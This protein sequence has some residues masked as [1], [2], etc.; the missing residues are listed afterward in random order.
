MEERLAYLAAHDPGT[1]LPNRIA[2]RKQVDEALE[3]SAPGRAIAVLA[4]DID[5]FKLVNDALGQRAGDDFLGMIGGRLG[6]IVSAGD[7]VA[8]IGADEFAILMKTVLNKGQ[9]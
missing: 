2:F 5:D 7:V 6:K 4:V 1:N 3:R 8:R 9:P